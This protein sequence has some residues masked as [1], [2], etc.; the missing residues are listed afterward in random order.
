MAEKKLTVVT[1]DF[2]ADCDDQKAVSGL[3]AG[4]NTGEEI[5]FIVNGPQ[6][7]LAAA[8]IAQAYHKKTGN[9]PLIAVGKQF[10]DDALPSDRVYS[11]T[12]GTPIE[13]SSSFIDTTLVS[14]EQLQG[15]IDQDVRDGKIRQ[16]EQVTLAPLHGDS[17]YY[18]PARLSEDQA[19]QEQWRKIQ[20]T[21]TTQFQREKGV[22]KGNNYQKSAHGV[23]DGY[24]AMLQ[25][26]GFTQV[27]F[28]GAVAKDPK[29][30]ITMTQP[31]LPGIEKA[32]ATYVEL[33]QVPWL[34]MAGKP[35][36]TP[37]ADAMHAGMFTSDAQVPFGV[38]VSGANPAGFGAERIMKE[39]CGI[40]PNTEQY[41]E[42]IV[43]INAELGN[44]DQ[45]VLTK[46]REQHPEIADV[47]QMRAELHRAMVDT[48]Q[49]FGQERGIGDP[50]L[51]HFTEIFER[52]KTKGTPLNAYGY[53]KQFKEL[54]FKENPL[55]REITEIA[56][57][58]KNRPRAD[59]KSHMETMASILGKKGARGVAYDAVAVEASRVVKEN[60]LLRE[61]FT[62]D[63]VINI[64]AENVNNLKK[65][66]TKLYDTFERGVRSGLSRD[67]GQLAIQQLGKGL[68]RVLSR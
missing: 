49:K 2:G 47:R 9:Y 7:R 28:D 34:N 4:L 59:G 22:Y 16:F 56:D 57:A 15:K 6:P 13:S 54:L 18:N 67:G 23:A 33:K 3:I 48:L 10:G 19:F 58:E 51:E 60:R 14:P 27:Y 46:L 26:Q 30:L 61:H 66:N 52:A 68:I 41:E 44:F 35:G 64:S 42:S 8:A 12:D 29:F 24:I 17:E 53:M 32:V 25:D 40:P 5:A 55:A 1:T 36:T 50:K 21:S 31:E 20:K 39:V 37:T 43:P 38:H 11:L 45:Q 63:G 62:E 65:R